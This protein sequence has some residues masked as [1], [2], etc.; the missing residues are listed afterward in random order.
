MLLHRSVA[1]NH[2]CNRVGGLTG[3]DARFTKI[4]WREVLFHRWSRSREIVF[5]AVKRGQMELR[6]DKVLLARS[7]KECSVYH[8][9]SRWKNERRKM[10]KNWYS[11]MNENGWENARIQRSVVVIHAA[12]CL[13]KENASIDGAP[14][15]GSSDMKAALNIAYSRPTSQPLT[16]PY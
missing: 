5:P 10:Q 4:H 3:S 16:P 13:R 7:T 1:G 15:T 9:V 11:C 8:E 6:K 14:R 2:C 12:L